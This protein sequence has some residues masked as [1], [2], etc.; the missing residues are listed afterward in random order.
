MGIL[1]MWKE[2][3]PN[4]EMSVICRMESGYIKMCYWTGEQW[5]D[6]WSDTLECEVKERMYIP[7]D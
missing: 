6:M 1:K 7:Y 5:L 3:H 4:V 2:G